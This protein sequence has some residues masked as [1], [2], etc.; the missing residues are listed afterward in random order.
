MPLSHS[1]L[2]ASHQCF[3]GGVS[4]GMHRCSSKAC[5][6]PGRGWHCRGHPVSAEALGAEWAQIHHSK[7]HATYV[8]NFNAA[9]EKYKE[10]EVKGDVG[11][12]IALQGAIK[13]NGGGACG[14][15]NPVTRR[16]TARLPPTRLLTVPA[17]VSR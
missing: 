14:P 8:T 11:A 16:L 9:M 15:A 10:A 5:K 6:L 4:N 7:H 17:A 3:T 2:P 1:P 13:F 12:M